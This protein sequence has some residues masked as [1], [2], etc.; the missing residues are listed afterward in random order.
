M[1]TEV[2]AAG[3]TSVPD[4]DGRALARGIRARNRV[5]P[6]FVPQVAAIPEALSAVVHEGDVVL[7]LGAGDIGQLPSLLVPNPAGER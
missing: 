1:L 2:Y 3:E 7:T 5:E 4:A 6:I